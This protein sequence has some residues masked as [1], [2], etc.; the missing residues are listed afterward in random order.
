MEK[1]TI[2]Q[3]GIK[4]NMALNIS[5]L[6]FVGVMWFFNSIMY[7]FESG[8]YPIDRIRVAKLKQ[9]SIFWTVM[10]ITQILLTT[11]IYGN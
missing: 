1:W 11:S 4:I 7:A 5:I 6:I 9:S 10:F 2:T 8:E 3:H